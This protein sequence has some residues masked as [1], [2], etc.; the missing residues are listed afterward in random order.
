[1]ANRFPLVIDT[2]DG[3][4]FKELPDGDNLILTNSSIVN[5]LNVSAVGYVEAT[6]F[7]LNGQDFTADYNELSNLPTI[8]SQIT[9]LVNDGAY[10]LV[11]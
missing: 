3:N 10:K 1:M 6:R 11:L 2:S 5:A 4:K 7:I 9:D 8:P